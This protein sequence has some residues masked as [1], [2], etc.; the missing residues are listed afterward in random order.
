MSGGFFDGYIDHL[1]IL[2][3]QA[4]TAEQILADA[5]LVAYYS[6]DCLS[7]TSLDSGPNQIHG[8]TNDLSSGDGGRIGQSYLFNSTSS[9]FQATG[10]VLLGQSYRPYSFA[11]WLRPLVTTS[12]TIVHISE[13]DVGGGWCVQFIGFNST[14][15]IIINSITTGNALVSIIGPILKIGEW[16]HIAQTYSETNGLRLYV[17]GVLYE[18]TSAFPYAARGLPMIMTLGQPLSGS[19]CASGSIQG[20]QYYGQIDE[21]YLFSRE[22]TQADVTAL[23][24]P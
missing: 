22:L 21:F 24:Q 6:M 7:Y 17:N 19:F 12:G 8:I 3:N 18:Q 10:F 13:T 11:M 2:V 15:R 20:G 16:V 1:T 23:A 5:T 4:K 9:Y 14:G